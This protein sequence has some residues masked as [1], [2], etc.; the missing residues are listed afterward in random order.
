[1]YGY[2]KNKAAWI[3]CLPFVMMVVVVRANSYLYSGTATSAILRAH[4]TKHDI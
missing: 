1:M 3:L 4:G 2:N